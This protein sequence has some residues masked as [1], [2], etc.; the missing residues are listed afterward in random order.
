MEPK[1]GMIKSGDC[2]ELCTD[3]IDTG[4]RVVDGDSGTD[5]GFNSLTLDA[6]ESLAVT[7][8]DD[9]PGALGGNNFKCC[10]S[11]CS[12]CCCFCCGDFTA[13]GDVA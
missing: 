8:G 1:F 12:C 9:N 2:C 11:C 3:A 10:C 7:I 4:V 6:C 5:N 13:T